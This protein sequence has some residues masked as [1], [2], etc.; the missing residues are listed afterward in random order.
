MDEAVTRQ[1]DPVV[2]KET[3]RL[4]VSVVETEAGLSELE[5]AWNLLAEKA[6]C[7]V[8]QTY[9]WVRTWWDH[10]GR[11][12]RLY[13]LVFR[14]NDT[15]V[16]IVPLLRESFRVVGIRVAT[17]IRFFSRKPLFYSDMVIEPGYEQVVLGSF[18]EHL[19]SVGSI[20]D[21]FEMP[22]IDEHFPALSALPEILR[23]AGI[24]VHTYQTGL[25]S[26][27]PLPATWDEFMKNLGGKTRHEFKRKT[28][29][30]KE[31][32]RVETEVVEC[33]GI[34]VKNAVRQMMTIHGQRWE[35]LGFRN[36]YADE[37]EMSF[38]TTVA[39]RFAELGW[40]RIMFMKA[41]G[42]KV[43]GLLN[44]NFGGRIYCYH[45]NVFG[46]GEMMKYSPGILLHYSAIQQGIAEGMR[47]YDMMIGQEDYK[48]S[49][50]KS[51]QSHVWQIRG[52]SPGRTHRL[53]FRAY[54]ILEIARKGQLRI[55][56]E[57]HVV[58]RFYV[59]TKP[60]PSAMLKYVGTR[61]K[62]LWEYE[63]KHFVKSIAGE[64]TAEEK[65]RRPPES[66]A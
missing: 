60:S 1:K 32:F 31:R 21:V 54:T 58:K 13:C 39:E 57:Y 63:R 49:D 23:R 35:S 12:A 65:K 47:E 18:A 5:Q 66:T 29:R 46:S 17:F 3:G 30:M 45:A 34:E 2:V 15:V 26:R 44:F 4:S 7:P 38:I 10:F 37:T 51:V 22:N 59:T 48:F 64:P 24:G 25:C 19:L 62:T 8:F 14:E 11:G 9:Q 52:I 56:D 61:I 50:V 28:E 36:R 41:D 20:W 27:V 53:R 6:N 33:G 55:A 43:A 40:L 16:G 42:E